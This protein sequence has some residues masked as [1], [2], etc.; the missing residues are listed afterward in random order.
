MLQWI[1][2]DSGHAEGKS[3]GLEFRPCSHMG[4]PNSAFSPF[5][6]KSFVQ[7][8]EGPRE[9][10]PAS[11]LGS[12]KLVQSHRVCFLLKAALSEAGGRVRY[13]PQYCCWDSC[14]RAIRCTCSYYLYFA[15]A[16]LNPVSQCTGLSQSTLRGI[17]GSTLTS[18]KIPKLV[19]SI[20]LKL[21]LY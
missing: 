1:N 9:R 13:N 6:F 8:R 20:G 17:K 11:S 15:T 10:I 16:V 3:W 2:K 5:Y 21:F 18:I 4:S 14:V 12:F 19:L 7:I